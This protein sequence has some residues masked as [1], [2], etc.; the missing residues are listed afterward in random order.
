MDSSGFEGPL[1]L[2]RRRFLGTAGLGIGAAALA[3]LLRV[4]LLGG[5]RGR[6]R[7]RTG[8]L[9]GIAAFCAEGQARHLHVSGRRAVAARFVR[10]QAEARQGAGH[11]P[12][13]RCA[14]GQ[15]LTAMTAGRPLSGGAVD[16][17]VCAARAIGR[18]DERTA[19][20][21]PR[22]WPTTSASSSRCI[23]NRSITT[24]P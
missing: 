5:G 11:R 23:R 21:T 6:G 13:R 10:L 16:L 12:A 14:N 9:A 18:V 4:D 24:R 2:T 20:A 3:E 15:R 8:G 1:N 22:R 19:A 17:Q 7:R